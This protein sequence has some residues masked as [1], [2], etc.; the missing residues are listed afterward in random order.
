MKQFLLVLFTVFCVESL[1]FAQ[2]H[3]VMYVL[4]ER[5][6]YYEDSLSTNT[7]FNG[8][9]SIALN[10]SENFWFSDGKKLRIHKIN[11]SVVVP[12]IYGSGRADYEASIDMRML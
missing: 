7:Y 1:L 10:A 2:M 12:I 6:N 8:R 4:G 5:G 9:Q 11:A 3:Y